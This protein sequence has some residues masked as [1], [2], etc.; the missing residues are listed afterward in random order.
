HSEKGRYQWDRFKL[1]LPVVGPLYR[2]LAI[3]RFARSIGSL[4]NANIPIVTC[5]ELVGPT[6]DNAVLEE[7][8]VTVSKEL[9]K[10]ET[11][12]GPLRDARFFTNLAVS[13][14]AVGEE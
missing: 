1:S 8:M 12:A 4:Y 3:A 11:I 9:I 6:V 7:V 14:I 10:G 5:I 13:M 2:R